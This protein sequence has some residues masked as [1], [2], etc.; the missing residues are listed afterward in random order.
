M[1]KFLNKLIIKNLTAVIIIGQAII[2]VAINSK[3]LHPEWLSLSYNKIL[4]GE[5]WRVISFLFLPPSTSPILAIISWYILFLM[6]LNLEHY[7][8]EKHYNLYILTAVILTNITAFVFNLSIGTNYYLQSSIF[9]AFAF[10][11]PNFQVRLFFLIPVKI[12][13]IAIVN[14]L[15]YLWILIT[16]ST[17]EKLLIVASLLNFGIFFTKDIYIKIKYRGKIVKKHLEKKIN[18]NKPLHTCSICGRND[19]DNP[20]LSFRYCSK[21]NPEKCYCEDH[22]NHEHN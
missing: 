11:N 18:E 13:W 16:G 7:W 19:I 2:Y 21:C 17:G 9:L 8:G 12:K 6:G 4:N 3:F 20:H 1:N 10:L 14:W 5:V 15:L 22:I